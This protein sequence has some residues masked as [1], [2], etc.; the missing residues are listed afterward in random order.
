MKEGYL[1]TAHG[2]ASMDVW[3]RDLKTFPTNSPRN[4]KIFY[5][6]MQISR[7]RTMWTV[8]TGYEMSYVCAYQH[9]IPSYKKQSYKKR[10]V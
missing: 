1:N 10:I 4:S 7:K 9:S 5:I 2:L 6:Q 8:T 3:V